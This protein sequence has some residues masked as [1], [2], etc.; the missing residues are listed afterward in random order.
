MQYFLQKVTNIS[1][2]VGYNYISVVEGCNHRCC[3][4]YICCR[5]LQ[6]YL[7][8]KVAVA[9]G[10]NYICCR[11]LQQYLLQKVANIFVPE[12]ATIYV[13]EGYNCIFFRRLQIYLLLESCNCICCR[14]LQLYLL[15]KVATISVVA[16]CNYICCRR[17]N[18]I[19]CSTVAM[20]ARLFPTDIL[21]LRGILNS[22]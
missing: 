18:Y 13:A 9:E 5:R 1:V 12:E 16:G 10:F 14:R 3:R 4:N 15:Q 19:C 17:I 8:K 2:A 21:T 6:L 11:R 7:L 20:V 22:T